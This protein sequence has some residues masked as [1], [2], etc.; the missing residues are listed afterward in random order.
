MYSKR[1]LLMVVMH[2]AMSCVREG[3]PRIR[4]SR[5]SSL[6]FA[7][8]SPLNDKCYCQSKLHVSDVP[9]QPQSQSLFNGRLSD[10]RA[11]D[12]VAKQVQSKGELLQVVL[13]LDVSLWARFRSGVMLGRGRITSTS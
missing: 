11:V 1:L 10:G 9:E 12:V 2:P 13:V 3:A 6:D 4:F 8:C 5:F 7:V